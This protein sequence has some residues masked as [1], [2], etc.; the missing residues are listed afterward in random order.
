MLIGTATLFALLISATICGFLL[1]FIKKNIKKSQLRLFI[2]LSYT[3]MLICCVGLI[4]QILFSNMLNI[5]PIY[6]DYFVYI[7]TCFLPPC[8]YFLGIVYTHTKIQFKKI[9]ILLFLIPIITLLV[10]WTN[11]FH[12]LFYKKYS[13]YLEDTIIGPYTYIHYIYL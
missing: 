8:V 3:C 1:F 2:I 6:F 11:D 4:L 13:I 9:H 12:H 5:S 10:L 7:G